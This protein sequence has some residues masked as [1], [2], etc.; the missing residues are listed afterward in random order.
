MNLHLLS[1]YFS[2][3]SLFSS[4]KVEAKKNEEMLKTNKKAPPK[5]LKSEQRL[6]VFSFYMQQMRKS[7]SI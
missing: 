2:F 1:A 7:C 4:T 5:R 6:G 3:S